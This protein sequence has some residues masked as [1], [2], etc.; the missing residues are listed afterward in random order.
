MVR[1][2]GRVDPAEPLAAAHE[3]EERL[4]PCRRGG[5]VVRIVEERAGRAG[6]E[7]RVALLQVLLGDVRGS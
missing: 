5:G 2:G 4:A 7:D 3:V 6:E 1:V